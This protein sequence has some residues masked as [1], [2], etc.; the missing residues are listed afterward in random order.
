MVG[1]LGSATGAAFDRV[2]VLGMAEGLL[3][4]RPPVDPL[5]T[6]SDTDADPL[7]RRER[8]AQADRRALLAALASADGGR[9]VLSYARSDGAARA[10][11]PSRWLLE[12]AARCE[13]VPAL[14][15][16]DLPALFGPERPWLE[17]LASAYDGLRRCTSSADLADHRLRSVIAW[18][19][20]G[21]DL[22]RHPLAVRADLP[23]G[24][25]CGPRERAARRHSLSMTA[26]WAQSRAIRAWSCGRSALRAAHR[27]PLRSSAGRAARSSTCWSRC[28]G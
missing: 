21:H 8:Q 25:R 12:Q 15:A 2:Y 13:G 6:G 4:S 7:R 16:S 20:L 19:A 9:V 3:P 27:R 1:L 22:A 14:Y 11:H 18:H 23:L 17:R 5:A 28:C 24:R 26:I 10:S